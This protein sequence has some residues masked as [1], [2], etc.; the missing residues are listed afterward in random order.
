VTI[1]IKCQSCGLVN[2]AD[3]A[4]CRRCKKDLRQAAG[5]AESPAAHTTQVGP[6]VIAANVSPSAPGREI[7]GRVS[8]KHGFKD[9][10]VIAV[11]DSV[12]LTPESVVGSFLHNASPLG[13]TGGLAG[14]L[15]ARKGGQMAAESKR[16]LLE[17]PVEQIRS[18]PDNVVIPL[19][20]LR[21]IELTRHIFSAWVEF[22]RPAG[23]TKFEVN[24]LAYLEL[25]DGIE[26]RFPALYR[27][28]E[29]TA[30]LLE[31]YR[32]QLRKSTRR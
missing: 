2:F 9:W 16:Q 29:R 19:S 17:A 20:D 15:I 28:D 25:C 13:F 3:A 6:T 18:G 24:P 4:V 8:T 14:A 23:S 5:A 21:S 26:R 7:L 31:R 11:E 27:S 22:V 10:F 1:S 30:K 32:T 12:V